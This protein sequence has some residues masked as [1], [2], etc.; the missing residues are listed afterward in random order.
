MVLIKKLY[1]IKNYIFVVIDKIF[2]KFYF[3]VVN[4]LF[5]KRDRKY[6]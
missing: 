4:K 1:I 6:I 2:I 5:V 3:S